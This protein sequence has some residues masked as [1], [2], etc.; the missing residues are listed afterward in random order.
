MED[1]S[2]TTSVTVSDKVT[3]PPGVKSVIVF[4]DTVGGLVCDIDIDALADW[5][6]IEIQVSTDFW[7][8]GDWA[9]LLAGIFD[10][11]HNANF[12]VVGAVPEFRSWL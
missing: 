12:S 10:S 11:H 6:S 7:Q 2:K 4:T 1:K 3:V 5:G 9:H 8:H